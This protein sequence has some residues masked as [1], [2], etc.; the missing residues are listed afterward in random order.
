VLNRTCGDRVPVSWVDC[1]GNRQFYGIP[2]GKIGAIYR[3]CGSDPLVNESCGKYTIK[4]ECVNDECPPTTSSTSSTSSSTSTTSS[5]ST[6]AIPF[7]KS[8]VAE[9]YNCDGPYG[10]DV[11]IG[12]TTVC[13]EIDPNNSLTIDN[14]YTSSTPPLNV[15]YKVISP[16][17]TS[18][19]YEVNDLGGGYTSCAEACASISNPEL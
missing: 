9:M 6:T 13:S 4:E 5:S 12:T 14:F 10:C 18:P 19:I 2:S 7:V 16:A 15:I 3:V 17:I 8:Y 1:L 11:S